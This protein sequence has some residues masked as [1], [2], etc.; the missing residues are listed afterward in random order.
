MR[1]LDT[2]RGKLTL[3]ELAGAREMVEAEQVQLAVWGAD[4]YPECKEVL[5][6]VQF[7]GGLVAGAFAPDGRM[8]GF[9][10]SLPTREPEVQHSHRLA[11]LPDWR[12]QG[13]GAALKWYQRD[14][15]L[16]RGVTL[17]QWTV[18]PLRAE[19]AELNIRHLGA[20]S[21]EYLVDY[22][23]TMQGID[24]GAP[25]DRLLVD[26]PVA[27][28]RVAAL[29]L[30]TPPDEGFADAEPVN[31]LADGQPTALYLG[32]SAP[33]LLLRLP[34]RFTR[35]ADSDPQL[36]LEWRMHS[37]QLFLHYFERGYALT[38]F[39]RVG[40][41]A[42]LLEKQEETPHVTPSH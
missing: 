27:S 13:I 20:S 40:G 22:Y 19:N 6:A 11:V 34:E 28:P 42:Y 9:S 4:T 2:S 15:C 37:R 14:W 18:D 39:T 36:A 16:E 12:G 25:T 3:R 23:G 8:V 32:L 31:T 30:G 41:P 1:E 33:R 10:F 35:L 38:G 7:S 21:R 5:I 26:W 24:S 17:V 29:A